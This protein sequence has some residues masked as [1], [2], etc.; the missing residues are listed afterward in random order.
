MELD[1]KVSFQLLNIEI[2]LKKAAESFF[3]K[4]IDE[5]LCNN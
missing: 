2:S 4:M 1:I 5:H 3:M